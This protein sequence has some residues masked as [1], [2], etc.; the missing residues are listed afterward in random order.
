[1]AGYSNLLLAPCT[2]SDRLNEEKAQRIAGD[3]AINAKIPATASADNKLVDSSALNVALAEFNFKR[4]GLINKTTSKILENNKS[5]FVVGNTHPSTV[6]NNGL[7]LLNTYNNNVA[8]LIDLSGELSTVIVKNGL[9]IK[10]NDTVVAGN[11][12]VYDLGQR[13]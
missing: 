6:G 5:Y 1:M 3:N 12:L 4:V 9:E 13:F 7:C 10:M 11:W 8:T 2:N